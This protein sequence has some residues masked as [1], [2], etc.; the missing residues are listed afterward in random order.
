M[1]ENFKLVIEENPMYPVL[2]YAVDSFFSIFNKYSKPKR[3]LSNILNVNY[4]IS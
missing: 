3:I 4:N 1:D 2:D